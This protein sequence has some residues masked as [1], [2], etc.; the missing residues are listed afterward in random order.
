MFRSKTPAQ[1]TYE[2]WHP[3]AFDKLRNQSQSSL[4]STTG[5]VPVLASSSSTIDGVP[6]TSQ[7]KAP[8]PIAVNLPL[9]AAGR[10]E[11]DQKV[12]SAF[13][14]LNSPNGTE[15]VTCSAASGV[16][17]AL[18]SKTVGKNNTAMSF[19]LTRSHPHSCAIVSALNHRLIRFWTQARCSLGQRTNFDPRT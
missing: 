8:A 9:H 15:F 2:V 16:I 6:S 12:F 10:K 11:P 3:P 17:F 4:Q 18:Q 14:F 13:K 7:R 19:F 5:K 1:K